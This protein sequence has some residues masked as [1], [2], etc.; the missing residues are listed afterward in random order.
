MWKWPN[1]T[2]EVSLGKL[3]ILWKVISVSTL[4]SLN[5]SC[6]VLC[7][8]FLKKLLTVISCWFFKSQRV[9]LCLR[10]HSWLLQKR[11]FMLE[12]E[13]YDCRQG[14]VAKETE[15]N[16]KSSVGKNTRKHV[17]LVP[18]FQL[19]FKII[20]QLCTLWS[21]IIHELYKYVWFGIN[22]FTLT[23]MFLFLEILFIYQLLSY[24]L[25][26]T[27]V[28]KITTFEDDAVL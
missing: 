24:D 4:C 26:F 14:K 8:D 27:S 12:L 21:I 10:Y 9:V 2:Y 17:K 7:W 23:R 1:R 25:T 11:F 15:L 6:L 5:F 18:S 19:Y 16:P 28:N 13:D 22:V 3:G 20:F